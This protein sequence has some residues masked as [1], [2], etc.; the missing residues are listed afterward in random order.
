MMRATDFVQR[1]VDIAKKYKTVY[2]WGCFG[3]PVTETVIRDKAAQY[4][5]WYTSERQAALRA[6]VGKGYFGF[7]C[8]NLTKAILWGWTGDASAT[9]GGAK[10]ASNSVPDINAD[11][12]ITRCKSVSS[13]SWAAMLPGEG[14][15]MPGHWGVYI[16]DG[17]AVEC[18][19]AWF[20]GVQISA[21]GNIGAKSGYPSRKWTKH[22]RLP[23]VDYSAASSAAPNATIIVDGKSYPINRIMA[24][25]HNYFPIRE[26]ADVLRAAGVCRLDVD[27]KGTIAVLRSK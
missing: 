16:G 1:H 5:E 13:G 23:W 26:I 27:N 14:L 9:Y 6:L 22:G 12:M 10:Y 15:W 21:V 20:G 24:N 11:T 3:V 7:D 19:P 8:I 25:G 2:M 18:T 17:L 4:P